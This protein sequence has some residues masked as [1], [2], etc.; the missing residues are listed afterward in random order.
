MST[1]ALFAAWSVAVLVVLLVFGLVFIALVD[2]AERA[3]SKRAADL[4]SD[5]WVESGVGSGVERSRR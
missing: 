1:V 2:Q 3:R 5:G 4:R